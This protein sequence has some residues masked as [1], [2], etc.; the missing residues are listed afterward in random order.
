[1]NDICF[2]KDDICFSLPA[3][4]KAPPPTGWRELRESLPIPK[5]A[6]RGLMLQPGQLVLDEDPRNGGDLTLLELIGDLPRTRCVLT[7]SGGKH[8][9]FRYDPA[10]RITNRPLT[11]GIDVKTHGG[12]VLLPPSRTA[13]GKYELF[14]DAPI[15]D[16]PDWLLALLTERAPAEPVEA[17]DLITDRQL[18][19]LRSAMMHP[20]FVETLADNSAWSSVGYALLSLG[21]VGR[22]LWLE[23]CPQW[24]NYEPG[25][26]ERWWNT[27]AHEA[28]RSDF[29]A[30]FRR[31]GVCGWSNPIAQGA[32]SPD[33]FDVIAGTPDEA[34]T[35]HRTGP[36]PRTE[37]AITPDEI[38]NAELTPRCI[39]QDHLY[40]DVAV[41][42]APGG[43]GK[44]TLTLYEA[45]H[46][47]L[48]LPL[49]GSQV[50]SPGWVLLVTAED[51]RGRL[52][53]RL[54]RIMD[55]MALSNEQQARVMVSV[56]IWDVTGEQIRMIRDIGGTIMLTELA[57]QIVAAYKDDPPALVEFDPAISFGASES[58]VNDNEQGLI[59]AA[60]RI[61]R[62][63]DCCV[64][65]VHHT[66]K[67]NAREKTVDQYSGRGGSALADGS[68][69]TTVIQGWTLDDR[70]KARPPVTLAVHSDDSVMILYR[71]KLS[72]APPN[73][74]PIWIRR[75]GWTFEWAVEPKQSP[76]EAKAA[77]A[78]QLLRFIESELAK[79]RHHNKTTLREQGDSLGMTKRQIE[80]T[81]VELT[82]GGLLVSHT[83]PPE[84]R[85]GGRK[86]Y[87]A[88]PAHI[89]E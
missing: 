68:R 79:D 4:E 42:V 60:R 32:C 38:G 16:V 54:G 59:L 20:A 65:Y 75:R 27:H 36:P 77:R 5:G 52:V 39:V 69:M 58:R 14:E 63:L 48:G 2:S 6:N 57:D 72:Y 40:A 9:Y 41:K 53:A 11:T 29:R 35:D 74:P 71:A 44:T 55:G 7:P 83:L 47:V 88:P 37:L 17:L 3:G 12:Y 15:A 64:R 81:I 56:C 49:Y 70:A 76:D 82:I 80:Q 45:V 24:P 26:D 50:E 23:F 84:R 19:D 1:M 28:P 61:V 66:G 73:Q 78:D 21:E 62:G 67:A 46:V 22:D 10:L 33:D 8:L 43:T 13:A 51:S 30:I 86:E 18:A 31:A 34:A 25:A 89:G 87:L 85:Q